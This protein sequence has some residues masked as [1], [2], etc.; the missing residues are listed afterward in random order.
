[1]VFIGSRFPVR[2]PRGQRSR[3]SGL[4]DLPALVDL[5]IAEVLGHRLGAD[6]GD[7]GARWRGPGQFETPG[8]GAEIEGAAGAQQAQA[9]VEEPCLVAVD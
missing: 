4:H 8:I 2:Y 9:A 5:P 7:H 1:M 6:I 3:I